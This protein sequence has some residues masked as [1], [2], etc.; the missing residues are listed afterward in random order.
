MLC[1]QVGRAVTV[2]ARAALEA[3]G[4]GDVRPAHTAVL[5]QL[6]QADRRSSDMAEVMGMTKQAVG[7]L[8][9]HLESGGYVRRVADPEDGRAKRVAL[10]ARGRRAAAV[11]FHVSSAFERRSRGLLGAPRHAD[12][13]AALESVL[14]S[15]APP[16]P[17]HVHNNRKGDVGV[18]EPA[19]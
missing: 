17:Q 7:L 1:R 15:A 6:T 5:A 16:R 19:S 2:E 9:D 10:T 14:S 11:A 18:G 13:K 12:I 4:F 3:A 8:V